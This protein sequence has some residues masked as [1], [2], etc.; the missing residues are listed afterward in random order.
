[1]KDNILNFESF[2][3]QKELDEDYP[4]FLV[5][6][7]KT[8]NKETSPDS[9]LKRIYYT[10]RYLEGHIRAIEILGVLH[11]K[12]T[13]KDFLLDVRGNRYIIDW[14]EDILKKLRGE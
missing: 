12:Q 9:I 2:K 14:V 13:G 10:L 1:M 11:K 4:T 5:N 7:E 8:F 3:G 6:A